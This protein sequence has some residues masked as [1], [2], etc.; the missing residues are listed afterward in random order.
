MSVQRLSLEIGGLVV[1]PVPPTSP[2]S[3]G[4]AG[5]EPAPFLVP[6]P[7]IGRGNERAELLAPQALDLAL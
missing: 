6:L 5:Q 2:A 7:S 3:T 4:V 1:R